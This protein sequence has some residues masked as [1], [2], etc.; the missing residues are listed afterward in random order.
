MVSLKEYC[1]QIHTVKSP[2]SEILEEIND[3]LDTTI[4]DKEVLEDLGV[5]IKG[6][7]RPGERILI[8]K[9][10]KLKNEY[11]QHL[12]REGK[13][14]VKYLGN[15]ISQRTDTVKENI[16]TVTNLSEKVINEAVNE[17]YKTTHTIIEESDIYENVINNLRVE[18]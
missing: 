14:A 1:Q 12:I 8:A 17:L 16:T 2:A 7:D 15:Y 13:E 9:A 10:L 6:R 11:L 3:V 18:L 5:T 4:H